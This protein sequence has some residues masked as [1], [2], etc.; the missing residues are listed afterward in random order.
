[1]DWLSLVLKLADSTLE[2]MTE[3]ERNKYKD[4]KIKLEKN[5]YE[6]K[7]KDSPSHARLDNLEHELFVLC[8]AISAQASRQKA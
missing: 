7:N 2:F 6:E 5:Y 3:K 4:T 8:S 1:M